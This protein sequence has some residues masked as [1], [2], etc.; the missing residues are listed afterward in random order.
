MEVNVR[1][2]KKLGDAELEIM[3]VLW[4][5]EVPVTSTYILEKMNGKRHWALSTLMTILARL[6]EKNCV[7]CDR[8]TRTNYYTALMNEEAYKKQESSDI[9][10]KL[11]N[12]S[13]YDLVVSLY[14]GNAISKEDLASLR[15][16]IDELEE[17]R[18]K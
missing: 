14:H 11:F 1:T 9:L 3:Q 16:M 12:N 5:A 17:D 18:E 6:C 7:I 4:K 8:S 15:K 2:M 13:I 10:G